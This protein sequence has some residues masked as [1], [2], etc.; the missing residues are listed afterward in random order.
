MQ[1]QDELFLDREYA[2]VSLNGQRVVQSEH[3]HQ[4]YLETVADIYTLKLSQTYTFVSNRIRTH[5]E[6]VIDVCI[7]KR[8]QMYAS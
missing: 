6:I 3:Q 7:M 4:L 2:S 5:F 1:A 8:S